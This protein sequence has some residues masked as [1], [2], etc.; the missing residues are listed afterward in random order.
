MKIVI[1]ML[2]AGLAVNIAAAGQNQ[3]QP[4]SATRPAADTAGLGPRN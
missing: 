4:V 1:A 3:A 2:L